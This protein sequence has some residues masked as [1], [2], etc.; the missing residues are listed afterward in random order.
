M[1]NS[2]K[3]LNWHQSLAI[4]VAKYFSSEAVAELLKGLENEITPLAIEK[5]RQLTASL[6]DK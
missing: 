6:S 1:N 5:R 2:N 3:L 4:A